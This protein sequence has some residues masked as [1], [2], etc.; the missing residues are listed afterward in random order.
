M[1]KPQSLFSQQFQS[2]HTPPHQQLTS[3]VNT[4]HLLAQQ[5]Y[6][7]Q[8]PAPGRNENIESM[9]DVIDSLLKTE[10]NAEKDFSL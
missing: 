7:K 5:I 6:N 8:H 3:H 9:D 10:G 2:A 4:K 1:E